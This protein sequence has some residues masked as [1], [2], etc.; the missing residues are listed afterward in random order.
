MKESVLVTGGAG[1]IGSHTTVEL[2][3]AGFG[4]VIADNLSNAELSAV[5]NVRKI[6]GQEIPFEEVD[7][8]CYEDFEKLFL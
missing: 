1:F 7:C 5:E 4:V 6:T 3:E 8:C 2:V